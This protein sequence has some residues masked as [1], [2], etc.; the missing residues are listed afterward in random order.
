[1]AAITVSAQQDCWV[2]GNHF[3]PEPIYY[4]DG[5]I[6]DALLAEFK[7]S[8]LLVVVVEGEVLEEALEAK[9]KK[10]KAE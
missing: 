10:A 6:N 2:A 8:P 7:A 3:T 9:T 5:I 1:M 4:R